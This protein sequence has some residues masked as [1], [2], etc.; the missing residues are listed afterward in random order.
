MGNLSQQ[1]L[2]AFFPN[3]AVVVVPSLNSTES[4]GLVQVEAML[5]GTPSIA[6]AL[7]GVR[8][9]VLQT[10]MGLAVPVGDSAALADAIVQVLGDRP[11][12]VRPREEI[13]A[14]FSTERTAAEYEALFEELR[15]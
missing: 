13:A 9:P 12:Y 10:G 7:P 11:R 4:F 2:A 3:C 8:Q 1:E 6:S 5:S 15:A 14:R